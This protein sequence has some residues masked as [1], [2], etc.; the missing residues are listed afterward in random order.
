MMAA[1]HDEML[2][3]RTRIYKTFQFFGSVFDPEL[4]VLDLNTPNILEGFDED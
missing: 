3:G 1:S 2:T 4:Q